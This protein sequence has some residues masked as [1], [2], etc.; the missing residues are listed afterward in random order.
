MMSHIYH[1]LLSYVIPY[2]FI[3]KIFIRESHFVVVDFVME[4]KKEKR[5]GKMV[6]KNGE[7][8]GTELG[9]AQLKLGFNFT[10]IFCTIKIGPAMV[11]ISTKV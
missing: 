11:E 2:L 4:K 7:Q 6:K 3:S 8:V 9:Q 1:F 5:W 10:L